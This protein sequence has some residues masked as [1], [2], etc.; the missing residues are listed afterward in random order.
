MH[1]IV[2]KDFLNFYN[3][4]NFYFGLNLLMY[5]QNDLFTVLYLEWCYQYLLNNQLKQQCG[6]LETSTYYVYLHVIK[7]L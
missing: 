1:L 6:S 5:Y 3:G 7:M 2:K 4:L